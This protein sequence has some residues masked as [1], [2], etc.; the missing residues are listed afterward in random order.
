MRKII[1]DTEDYNTYDSNLSSFN[2][3]KWGS[4]VR[5]DD[6]VET[7]K[8]YIGYEESTAHS[9]AEEEGQC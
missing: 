9:T 7:F 6:A 1:N 5:P 8:S 4:L 2:R 3:M